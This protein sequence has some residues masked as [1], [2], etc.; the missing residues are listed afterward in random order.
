MRSFP[1]KYYEP[2]GDVR[3]SSA[4]KQPDIRFT[5][6]QIEWLEKMYPEITALESADKM[7]YN[8]GQRSVI[9]RIKI[10]SKVVNRNVSIATDLS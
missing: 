2:R 5:I 6:Q 10:Q 1:S 4:Q 3:M 7:A 8:L 9:N